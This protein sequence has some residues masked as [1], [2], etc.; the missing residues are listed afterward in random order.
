MKDLRE[1]VNLLEAKQQLVRIDQPVSPHL[2][3]TEITDRISK[4]PAEKNKALLFENVTGSDLPVLINAFGNRQRMSWALGVNDLEQLNER[5]AAL[6]DLRL[7]DGFRRMLV[8][9]QEL[10]EVLRSI[11]MGPKMVK[12][13]PV[14]EIVELERPSLGFLPILH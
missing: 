11:G 3:I 12:N 7:P 13:G 9:G 1:F 5:L 4:S 8:R 2:E 14:Q 6:L 10:L